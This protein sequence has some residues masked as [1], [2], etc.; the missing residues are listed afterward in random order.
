MTLAW[1]VLWGMEAGCKRSEPISVRR[2][3]G[4]EPTRSASLETQGERTDSGTP[5]FVATSVRC[6]ECH[7]KMEREWKT[8]AHARAAQTPVYQAMRSRADSAS[9]DRCHAPLLAV[10]DP[11]EPAAQEGVSCDVC[12][13]IAELTPKRSG[14]G[15]ALRVHDNIKYGPLC[16]AK[17]HYFHRMGCSP[18]HLDSTLCAGCHLLY[19][20]GRGGQ[21]LPVFTE[22]EEWSQ[23][24]YPSMG[25]HCQG[26]HM[27]EETAEVAVGSPQRVG[28]A[29]HGFLGREGT[30]R[31]EAIQLRVAV[32]GNQNELHVQVRLRN[33]GAGHK[34]PTG[35]PGKRLLLRV[36]T[37]DQAGQELNRSERTYARILVDD[38]GSEVPFF[39][40]T[41]L[42][43]DN[44][45]APDEAR[46]ESF[47][48]VGPAAGKLHIEL[49]W[50]GVSDMAAN[51]S[52]EPRT[53]QVLRETYV[54][55]GPPLPG[56]GRKLLP[57]VVEVK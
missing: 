2:V 9:C 13:T 47:D 29:H 15:F 44:R 34:V 26:C 32:A 23:G 53:D 27:P 25:I 7:G 38:R 43:L 6:G 37:L 19:L 3:E 18:L 40:A 17:D 51:I 55:F 11:S 52:A 28:V 48:L 8:S 57:K 1:P 46:T 50:R 31:R 4:A 33:T 45:L 20:P 21:E 14:A 30:L 16:D 5:T 49:V 22:Y 56:G 10:T 54:A 12:H 39:S 36:R 42:A 35:F 24:P 41:R